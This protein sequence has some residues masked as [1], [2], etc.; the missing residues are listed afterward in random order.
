MNVALN[1]R[2]EAARAKALTVFDYILEVRPAPNFIEIVASVGGDI[3][4]RRYYDD[5]A[6]TDR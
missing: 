1:N 6:E 4:V 5:G 2:M 3:V